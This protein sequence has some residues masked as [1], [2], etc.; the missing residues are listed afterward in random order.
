MNLAGHAYVAQGDA[1]ALKAV[2]E[3]LEKEGIDTK[4][5]PDVLVRVY[6]SFTIDDARSLRERAAL[7]SIRGGGRTFVIVA[8]T[9][10]PDAQNALLKTFEEPPAGACFI[11][12]VPSPEM[13]LPT[14]RSRTQHLSL[15]GARHVQTIVNVQKFL[16]S[17][18]EKRFEMLKPFLDKGEDERRDLAGTISFLSELEHAL[19]ADPKADAEGLLAIYR[20]R[21][22][23]TDRGA[24]AKP[25]LEQMALLIPVK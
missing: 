1:D 7:H 24:L 25:L 2:L 22:Y 17:R 10:A 13:L 16:S 9:I 8:P 18:A 23:I 15:E 5:N 12:V 19:A 4:G 11:L 14:L 3:I 21:K 6:S 20:A